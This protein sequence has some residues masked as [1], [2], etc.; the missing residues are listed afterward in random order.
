[1]LKPPVT[2]PK[3]SHFLPLSQLPSDLRDKRQN[4]QEHGKTHFLQGPKKKKKVARCGSDLGGRLCVRTGGRAKQEEITTLLCST[5]PF[6]NIETTTP[7][8]SP[9][10][11]SFSRTPQRHVSDTRSG[12][13]SGV[14]LNAT[15]KGQFMVLQSRKAVKYN[16]KHNIHYNVL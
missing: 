11:V 1:M 14:F 2:D 7:S 9:I 6:K 13:C 15:N 8:E 4:A 5:K 10:M 16:S 12:S 3:P